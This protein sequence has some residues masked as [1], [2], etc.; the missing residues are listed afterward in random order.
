MLGDELTSH[1]PKRLHG[2][3]TLPQV[4]LEAGVAEH[5]EHGRDDVARH[6]GVGGI[7]WRMLL[8]TSSAG[9]M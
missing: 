5:D 4:L 6:P 2:T 8:A 9:E 3:T 7:I 1:E